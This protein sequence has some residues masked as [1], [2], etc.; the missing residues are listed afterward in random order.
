MVISIKLI[1]KPGQFN[2]MIGAIIGVGSGKSFASVGNLSTDL[3]SEMV[4]HPEEDSIRIHPPNR[5]VDIYYGPGQGP[6]SIFHVP[7]ED[8]WIVDF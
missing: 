4:N 8:L 6:L 3:P 5:D 7:V 2:W 1:L